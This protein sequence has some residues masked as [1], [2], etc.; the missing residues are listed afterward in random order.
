MRDGASKAAGFYGWNSSLP[1]IALAISVETGAYVRKIVSMAV[2]LF[3]TQEPTRFAV[4]HATPKRNVVG[5]VAPSLSHRFWNAIVSV[6][7]RSRHAATFP[8]ASLEQLARLLG[9]ELH[10]VRITSSA[11]LIDRS[12]SQSYDP[13]A[14]VSHVWRLCGAV[15]NRHTSVNGLEHSWLD[16]F[17]RAVA[18]ELACHTGNDH[19]DVVSTTM[20]VREIDEPRGC[21]GEIR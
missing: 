20:V 12:I 21:G 13:R 6:P 2:P 9:S 10:A 18:V 8:F 14:V 16:H 1:Q 17:E 4:G 7:V 11:A 15:V 19:R 3:C 5:V